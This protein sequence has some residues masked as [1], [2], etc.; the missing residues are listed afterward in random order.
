M[1]TQN[2]LIPDYLFEVSW[3][4]CNKVGRIY[5]VISTKAPSIEKKLEDNYRIGISL[6]K[7]VNPQVIELSKK[8]DLNNLDFT[9]NSIGISDDGIILP[10]RNNLDIIPIHQEFI[11]N[12]H[13]HEKGVKTTIR[14]FINQMDNKNE[15]RNNNCCYCN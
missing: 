3:E 13:A 9:L 1:T 11:E 12:L 2:Q 15:K 5:T 8:S 14:N 6:L 10:L 7:E 4:V